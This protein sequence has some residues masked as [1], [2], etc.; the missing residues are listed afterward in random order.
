VAGRKEDS[1]L[2]VRRMTANRVSIITTINHNI[3]DDFVREGILYLLSEV[4]ALGKVELIHKHCPLTATYGF[5]SI[6]SLRLSQV[7]EPVSRAL[8]WANRMDDADLVVQSGAPVYWCHPGG[9]H[10]AEN[11]WFAPLIH[12]RFLRE[13]RGR[14]FLSIA[15]G[16]CQ[17]YH[18]TGNE[19]DSCFRCITYMRAF[20]D[21]CDLTLLRDSLAR[22]MLQRAGRDAEVLPCTSIFARDRLNLR[23]ADGEYIVL[24]FMENG[25]HFKFNQPID[26]QL[27]RTQFKRIADEARKHGRVIVAC[28]TPEEERLAAELVPEIER[29][30]APDDYHEFTRFYSRAKFGILNRVHAGFMMASFGKPAVVIGSD[31]R[32]LMM[33]ALNLPSIFVNDVAKVGAECIVEMARSRVGSYCDEIESIRDSARQAYISA[34][35]TALET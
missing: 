28:H 22:K 17:R 16:S 24:N 5:E 18:S 23:S 21:S 9:V 3:G 13:R 4:G 7:M 10:C 15:G 32:A 34:I 12:G 26:G 25:G 14:K 6:R 2:D 27:W 31:S 33:Q 8:R 30:L 1:S 20:F 35:S 11:E 29:F 19:V